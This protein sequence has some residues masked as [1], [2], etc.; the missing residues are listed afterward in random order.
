VARQKRR[1]DHAVSGFFWGFR[2]PP[3]TTSTLYIQLLRRDGNLTMV[4]APEKP[5]TIW[6]PSELPA[7]TRFTYGCS[8]NASNTLPGFPPRAGYPEMA[9][10]IPS[11][12]TG[13]ATSRAPPRPGT[14]FTV[15]YS[16]AVS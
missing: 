6:S 7:G 16:C 8:E 2:F 9:N 3:I 14:P 13:P 11:A 1:R 10:S 4:G 5:L 15:L 12:A